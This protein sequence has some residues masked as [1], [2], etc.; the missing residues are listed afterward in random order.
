[1]LNCVTCHS[2][3]ILYHIMHCITF[4]FLLGSVQCSHHLPVWLSTV[5]TDF[6]SCC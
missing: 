1:M 6:S 3:M 2:D 5:I 4:S